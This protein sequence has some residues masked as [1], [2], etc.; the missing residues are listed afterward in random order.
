MLAK[1]FGGQN[2]RPSQLLP[3]EIDAESDLMEALANIDEDEHP[4][5][6][7]V[8]I[9]LED[10]YVVRR[11]P[12]K[13]QIKSIIIVKPLNMPLNMPLIVLSP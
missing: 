3:A 6:G 5:D 1:L 13:L 4:D 12:S 2:K 11:D 7:A 9:L 8:E 10:E